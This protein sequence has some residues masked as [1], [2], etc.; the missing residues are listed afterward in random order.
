MIYSGNPG[1]ITGN[2]L[3]ISYNATIDDTINRQI[4]RDGLFVVGKSNSGSCVQGDGYAINS[5][6]DIS[7]KFE[8]N[9][10]YTCR[11]DY[12]LSEFQTFC[13]LKKWKTMSIFNF[14]KR[15]QYVGKFGNA[16]I[17]YKKVYLG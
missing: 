7:I 5:Y 12:T 4:E 1:Y 13:E 14:P 15:L 8:T 9:N 10:N 17:K 6:Q 3:L 2:N 11:R 16:D